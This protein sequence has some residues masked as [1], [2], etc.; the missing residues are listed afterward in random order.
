VS[1]IAKAARSRLPTAVD[2]EIEQEIGRT[3][4]RIGRTLDALSEKLAARRRLQRGLRMTS[5][6][7]GG[8]DRAHLHRE[9]SFRPD[10]LALGLIGVGIAW[11]VAENAEFLR[12]RK[13]DAASGAKSA[14]SGGDHRPG[15]G[16]DAA[17]DIVGA[18]EPCQTG[19]KRPTNLIARN[20]LFTGLFGV[21]AGAVLA[22]LLPAARGE[23]QLI[24]R[25]KEN[26]WQQ[27]EALG[28]QTAAR[29]RDLSQRSTFAAA[30]S[31]K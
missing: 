21:A 31:P 24:A 30:D 12:S 20:P 26:L 15:S 7:V 17:K 9:A 22:T 14:G 25:A 3:R 1:R 10:P 23:R 13:R 8:E 28:H 2:G 4:R 5:R 27:A 18:A 29:V 16:D 19:S 6:P 11:L